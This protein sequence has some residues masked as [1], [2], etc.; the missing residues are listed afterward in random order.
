MVVDVAIIG[1]DVG[2]AGGCG[3][4]CSCCLISSLYSFGW[5]MEDRMSSVSVFP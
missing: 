4:S 1:G 2:V 5:L 3:S